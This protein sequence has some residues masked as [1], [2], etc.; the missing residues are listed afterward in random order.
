MATIT[1]GGKTCTTNGELPQ[2][3]EQAP[4][5]Q[6][7]DQD[8]QTVR[9]SDF[10]GESVILNI[11]PSIDTGICAASTRRFNEEA[12]ELE[13]T[14]V[15]TVSKDLPFA[16][17]R[18]RANEGLDRI[19]QASAYRSPEFGDDYHVTIIDGAFATLFSRVVI[20][21]DADHRVIYT[22]QVPEIGHEP[23]YDAA[24]AALNA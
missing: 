1:L 14:K 8:M 6:L 7:I 19:L 4:D 10:V 15:I 9:L 16:L 13:N 11:F 21:L 5:F 22:E 18:F 2:L 3:G 17:K 20:V 24:I 23:D 12:Q